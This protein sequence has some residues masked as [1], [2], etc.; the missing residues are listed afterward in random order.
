[1]EAFPLCLLLNKPQL[2]GLTQHRF[3]LIQL[4]T[5]TN[6]TC[7]GLYEA[8]FREVNTKNHT[9]EKKYC[10]LF[11]TNTFSDILKLGPCIFQIVVMLG[12]CNGQHTDGIHTLF[13]PVPYS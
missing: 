3:I 7:F 1:M 12:S 4:V 9:K 8:I 6:V 2:F 5:L 10:F 13:S 11:Y